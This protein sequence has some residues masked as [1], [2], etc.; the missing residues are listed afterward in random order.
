MQRS[1]MFGCLLQCPVHLMGPLQ[2]SPPQRE[3]CS[4]HKKPCQTVKLT[5]NKDV[6]A[7]A[8]YCLHTQICT[9]PFHQTITPLHFWLAP[10]RD[11]FCWADKVHMF[12]ATVDVSSHICMSSA[13]N[14]LYI[15]V[16]I[17]VCGLFVH[18]YQL[19]SPKWDKLSFGAC[20]SS[21]ILRPVD[22]ELMEPMED[23]Y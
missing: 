11:A 19:I 12:I 13:I 17:S 16:F 20:S 15:S 1:L 21:A 5:E 14:K 23:S 10:H 7:H 22:M 8:N 18:L 9:H 4:G 3:L 2:S 6:E